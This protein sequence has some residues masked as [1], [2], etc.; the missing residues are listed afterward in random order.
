MKK[1]NDNAIMKAIS[2]SSPEAFVLEFKSEGVLCFSPTGSSADDFTLGNEITDY[3]QVSAQFE[4]LVN[5]ILYDITNK[6][7]PF[8]INDNDTKQIACMYC[9]YASLCIRKE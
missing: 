1:T 3:E 2:Y 5:K 4:W 7:I 6:D 8:A 9:P